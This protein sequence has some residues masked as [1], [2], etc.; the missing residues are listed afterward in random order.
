MTK[1]AIIGAGQVGA[2]AAQRIAES[3]I[4]DMVMVDIVDGIAAGKA[5]DLMHA[6]PLIPHNSRIEGSA[7]FSAIRGARIVVVTAGLPRQPGMTREDLLEKNADIM[8]SVCEH[9]KKHCPES[10][11]LVVSNPLDVMTYLAWKLTGFPRER[12]I[13]MGGVLDTARFTAQLAEVL[14]IHNSRI[15]ALVIG[16]HGKGMMPL[17]SHT[18]VNGTPLAEFLDEKTIAESVER[19]NNAGAEVV[20][21]LKKGSAFYAPA[22]AIMKMVSAMID[23]KDDVLPASV[24]LQGE[25]DLDDV[26]IGVPVLLCEAGLKQIVTID[27]SSDEK[28]QLKAGADSIRKSIDHLK[29]KGYF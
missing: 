8:R 25:Y 13:G 9:I 1:I 15:K 19:T 14:E 4:A 12:V 11:V 23:Q 24:V 17:A 7:D 16:P 2:T 18:T 21:H 3:G 26:T 20:E 6:A 29:A 28:E 10:I 5:L 22:A 27:L